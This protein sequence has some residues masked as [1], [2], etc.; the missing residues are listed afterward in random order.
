MKT[1]Q[2][3]LGKQA[4]AKPQAVSGT[5]GAEHNVRSLVVSGVSG[6]GMNVSLQDVL[7][8]EKTRLA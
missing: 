5:H 6:S 2:T 7:K 8:R 3:D 4:A 1:K